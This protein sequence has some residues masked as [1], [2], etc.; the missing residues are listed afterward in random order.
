MAVLQKE[1]KI[2]WLVTS[3][4]MQADF[5]IVTPQR[6]V[7]F[8][9][10]GPIPKSLFLRTNTSELERLAVANGGFAVYGVA[11]IHVKVVVFVCG[12]NMQVSPDPAVI[13]VDGCV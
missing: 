11:T 12:F 13:Q 5:S 10:L 6:K 9:F 8:K 4:G 1:V 7:L 3:K 2:G